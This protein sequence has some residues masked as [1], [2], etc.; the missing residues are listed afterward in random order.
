LNISWSSAEI[1]TFFNLQRSCLIAV[2]DLVMRVTIFVNC[3]LMV[4]RIRITSL[5][6]KRAKSRAP[7]AKTSCERISPRACKNRLL[8]KRHLWQC[9]VRLGV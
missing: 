9:L 1:A 2:H 5:I 7:R 4:K 3:D 6:A 8:D